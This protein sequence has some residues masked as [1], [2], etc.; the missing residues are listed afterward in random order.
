MRGFVLIFALFVIS[1]R[2]DDKTCD[3]SKCLVGEQKLY[4][5]LGCTP[6]V[7]EGQCC[8]SRYECP[9]L[10]KLDGKKCHYKNEVF[11]V[12]DTLDQAITG[13]LCAAACFCREADEYGNARFVC[14]NIEC[15]ELFRRRPDCIYQ[16]TKDKC[17]GQA[18]CG[19]ERDKLSRCYM[20][21]REF[22]EGEKMYPEEERCHTCI[23]HKEFDNSTIVGNPHCYEIDCG[24]QL[25]YM[26]NL[27]KNCVPVY[28][29]TNKCCPIDWRCPDDKDTVESKGKNGGESTHKCTFGALKLNVGEELNSSDKDVTCACVSP[30]FVQCVKSK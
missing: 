1:V 13:P 9:D 17:C 25:R 7:E 6:V 27:Q 29:G 28:Y 30:P 24:I 18:V 8:A 4:K 23:C 22:Y 19:D 11:N 5:E 10:T 21:G 16:K 14:A 20:D 15:P 26:T 12:Q 3:K 2:A